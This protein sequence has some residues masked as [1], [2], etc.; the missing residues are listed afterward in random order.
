MKSSDTKN[1]D[2]EVVSFNNSFEFQADA[3]EQEIFSKST[4]GELKAQKKTD[5]Y[6]SPEIVHR[7]GTS[8]RENE[9]SSGLKPPTPG[10]GHSRRISENLHQN[11]PAYLQDDRL[12]IPYDER[13]STVSL[14]NRSH[15]SFGSHGRSRTSSRVLL[16]N[17]SEISENKGGIDAKSS[18]LNTSR[19]KNLSL[20]S[21]VEETQPHGVE[22]VH[23]MEKM[24]GQ[25]SR[26]SS[27][28]VSDVSKKY[29]LSERKASG[30]NIVVSDPSKLDSGPHQSHFAM[31]QK[32]ASTARLNNHEIAEKAKNREK[33]LEDLLRQRVRQTQ[34]ETKEKEK[35]E[36]ERIA[37]IRS[38]RAEEEKKERAW[39]RKID[40]QYSDSIK[41]VTKN[42]TSPLRANEEERVEEGFDE[43]VINSH[44]ANFDQ[45]QG[46]EE[47]GQQGHHSNSQRVL[48]AEME[49]GRVQE[50]L[51][52]G[53]Q[54]S[55][56]SGD[57]GFT[58]TMYRAES[59]VIIKNVWC[60]LIIFLHI[61]R[62]KR[63]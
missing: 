20:H 36:L 15:D 1:K 9:K 50:T 14:T 39:S 7:L 29:S 46:M 8:R 38:K 56:I 42:N 55:N 41:A 54:K 31:S 28:E 43:I 24:F 6:D 10:T 5:I 3:P 34:D 18:R 37:Q 25:R 23:S 4:L 62:E 19:S 16:I 32:S 35:I 33:G 47:Q 26:R 30:Y 60:E 45:N 52:L 27:S 12:K 2:E 13:L 51:N 22:W 17:P 59:P 11:K 44:K 58:E 57:K 53:S 63:I 48:R 40:P 49:F 61:G 21:F